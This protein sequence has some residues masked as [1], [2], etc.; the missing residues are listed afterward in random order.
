MEVQLLKDALGEITGQTGSPSWDYSVFMLRYPSLKEYASEVV[1]AAEKLFQNNIKPSEPKERQI[2]LAA[3]YLIVLD[4]WRR[5]QNTAR[6]YAK[7]AA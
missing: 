3:A 6:L 1:Q 5:S 7:D 4:Q 2:E